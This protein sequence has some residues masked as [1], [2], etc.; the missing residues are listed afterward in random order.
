V[1]FQQCSA[2][3]PRSFVVD[4]ERN[5]FMKDGKPF[6]YVSGSMHYGRVPYFYW[7]DRLQRLAAAG[8]DAVQT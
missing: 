8:L 7:A 1:L 5:T 6:V 4:Y 3:V 2:A